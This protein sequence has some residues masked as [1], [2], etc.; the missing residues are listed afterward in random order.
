[1]RYN[2]GAPVD[3]CTVRRVS[4]PGLCVLRTPAVRGSMSAAVLP[5][6]RSDGELDE[7]CAER[8]SSRIG[9][10]D[11]IVAKDMGSLT[12]GARLIADSALLMCSV[13]SGLTRIRIG[14]RNC[15]PDGTS[16][17]RTSAMTYRDERL[18]AGIARFAV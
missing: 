12:N 15:L 9:G 7:N 14:S 8:D 4:P 16:S 2:G 17:S 13:E 1:M 18:F 3:R 6:R 11:T 10:G 5:L